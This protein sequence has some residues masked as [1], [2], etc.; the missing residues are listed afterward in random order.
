M[1]M[2]LIKIIFIS[3]TF[4]FIVT[5]NTFAKSE[6]SEIKTENIKAE[7]LISKGEYIEAISL[8]EK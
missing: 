7:K 5:P 6:V 3:I 2:Q 4:L 1:I 8:L